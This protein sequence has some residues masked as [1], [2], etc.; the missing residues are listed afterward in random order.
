MIKGILYKS[1]LV[2]HKLLL[3]CSLLALLIIPVPGESGFYDEG[4]LVWPFSQI[5]TLK[6]QIILNNTRIWLVKPIT[7]FFSVVII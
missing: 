3:G 2:C 6:G 1:R 5:K 4:E 7:I